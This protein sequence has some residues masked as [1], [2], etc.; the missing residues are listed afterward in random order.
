MPK[1]LDFF[2]RLDYDAFRR[3]AADP[4]LSRQ[5]RIGFPDSYREPFEAAIF[6]DICEKLPAILNSRDGLVVDIG[7]GVAGLPGRLQS[8][9]QDRGHR[10]LLVDSTEVLDQLPDWPMTEKRSGRF[11][12]ECRPLIDELAGQVDALLCYSVFH[13]VFVEGN[14]FDF[15]DSL[16]AMLAPGGA[17]LIGDVPN[18]SMRRRFFSSAKGVQFHRQFMQTE[19]APVVE[20]NSLQSG[21]IDDAVLIGMM[22][23][24]R[25]A[26]F[27]AYV[28]SQAPDLPMANRREDLLIRRP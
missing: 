28:V 2:K 11:P 27:D 21:Q 3:M 17:C 6:R 15:L 18:T 14:P 9:C 1:D 22:M 4:S 7:P 19:E 26:G 13:Y 16:L 24:A 5:E 12:Q 10:L 25:A 23:R 20:F 8:A